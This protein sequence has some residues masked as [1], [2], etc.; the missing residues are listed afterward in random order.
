M[1]DQVRVLL[2]FVEGCGSNGQILQMAH[3]ISQH[4][5]L[6]IATISSSCHEAELR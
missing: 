5:C 1:E 3:Y 4:K 2:R 6:E